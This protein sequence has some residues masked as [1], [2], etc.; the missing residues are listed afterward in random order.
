MPVA[1]LQGYEAAT[2]A[3]VLAD[4]TAAATTRATHTM[5]QTCNPEPPILG[6]V[7]VGMEHSTPGRMTTERT[8]K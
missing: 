8:D 3:P 7:R 4:V 6:A 2:R 1:L 5:P